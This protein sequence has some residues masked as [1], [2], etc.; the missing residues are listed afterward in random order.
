MTDEPQPKRTF[1][2]R[3]NFS[4]TAYNIEHALEQ[5]SEAIEELA[6]S[7]RDEEDPRFGLLLL[8]GFINIRP[9]EDDEVD[10]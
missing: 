5:L 8:D 3:A 2:V 10:A 6:E 4:F 7:V 1:R 9:D